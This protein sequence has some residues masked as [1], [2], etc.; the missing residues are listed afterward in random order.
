MVLKIERGKQWSQRRC[1]NR[2]RIKTDAATSHGMWAASRRWKR[3][4]TNS[5]LESQKEKQPY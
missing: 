5:P 3:Q 2:N 1:N 4:E